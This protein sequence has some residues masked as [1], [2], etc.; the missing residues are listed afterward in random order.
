VN[1]EQIIEAARAAAKEAPPLSAE[2]AAKVAA[3]LGGGH[4]AA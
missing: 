4:R 2:T 1:H 3:L